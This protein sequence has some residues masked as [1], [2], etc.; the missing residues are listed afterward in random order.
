MTIELPPEIERYVA[1]QVSRGNY[2]TANEFVAEVLQRQQMEDAM[3]I[4]HLR[5]LVSE[6]DD[7]LAHGRVSSIDMDEVVKTAFERLDAEQAENR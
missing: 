6:A 4:D 1:D 5:A 2:A 7:D 3:E